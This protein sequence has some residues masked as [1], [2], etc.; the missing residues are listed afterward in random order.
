MDKPMKTL[1]LDTTIGMPILKWNEEDPICVTNVGNVYIC[2][3][4]DKLSA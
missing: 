4:P 3:Q 1:S 2:E